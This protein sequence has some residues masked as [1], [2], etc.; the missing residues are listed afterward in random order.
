MRVGPDDK[1]WVVVDAKPS[2]EMADVLFESTLRGLELQFKGGMTMDEHPTVFDDKA[3]AE[4]E[5]RR[6][7]MVRKVAEVV[8]AETSKRLPAAVTRLQLLDADGKVVLDQD[9]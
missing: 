6:R 2:S 5:A 4:Q 1:I 7:L 9:I 8:G 3:E